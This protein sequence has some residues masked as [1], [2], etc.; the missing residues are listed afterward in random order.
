MQDKYIKSLTRFEGK[1]GNIA[2]WAIFLTPIFFVI[3]G[4]LNLWTAS[5]LSS[6][7]EVSLNDVINIMFMDINPK[8]EY[9]FSG[10]LLIIMQRLETS[11]Y[12]YLFSIPFFGI[13]YTMFYERKRDNEIIKVLRKHGEI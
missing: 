8:Q 13:A 3:M 5:K 9:P 12:Q 11:I 7:N 1:K 10:T 2:F 6:L 4:T